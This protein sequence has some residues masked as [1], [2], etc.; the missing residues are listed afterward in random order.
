MTAMIAKAEGEPS[1]SACTSVI[2]RALTPLRDGIAY[3]DRG[4]EYFDNGY[5]DQRDQ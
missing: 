2:E 1:I 3:L 4:I 5:Y